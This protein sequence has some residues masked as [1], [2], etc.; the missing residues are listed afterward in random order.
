MGGKKLAGGGGQGFFFFVE[1][2]PK[3]GGNLKSAP[4]WL[5]FGPPRV[6]PAQ[7][8]ARPRQQPKA[9]W[10]RW[11]GA[12]K[13]VVCGGGT[14]FSQRA[15]TP[16]LSEHNFRRAA[17]WHGRFAELKSPQPYPR[18]PFAFPSPM[19]QEPAAGKAP[20]RRKQR[21]VLL[22]GWGAEQQTDPGFDL[23]RRT[24]QGLRGPCGF[25]SSGAPIPTGWAGSG[26]TCSNRNGPGL[27]PAVWILAAP[28]AA[29][30][31]RSRFRWRPTVV[32]AFFPG[33]GPWPRCG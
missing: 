13:P 22:H 6:P 2:R 1:R 16:S 18:V 25:T 24:G 3:P 31:S 11:R 5:E 28:A 7:A 10:P 33:G 30:C 12:G 19:T 32:L 20:C 29:W 9:G 8:P 21:L 26:T 14:R 15:T 17:G 4:G 23:R 27:P